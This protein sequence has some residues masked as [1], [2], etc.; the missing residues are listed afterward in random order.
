MTPPPRPTSPFAES[1]G[2]SRR[3]AE[4]QPGICDPHAIAKTALPGGTGQPIRD[5]MLQRLPAH[6]ATD[7]HSDLGNA[8]SSNWP[9]IR[10]SRLTFCQTNSSERNAPQGGGG[11]IGLRSIEMQ[12]G[13]GPTP[14]RRMSLGVGPSLWLLRLRLVRPHVVHELAASVRL[15]CR[16][17]GGRVE[18]SRRDGAYGS[19]VD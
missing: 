9:N 4:L 19:K 3:L 14:G 15:I 11:G 10:V 1:F 2:P 7:L 5:V 18:A 13:M 16:E 6:P 12:G 17:R 8:T